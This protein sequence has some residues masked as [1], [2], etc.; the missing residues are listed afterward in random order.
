MSSSCPSAEALGARLDE[1]AALKGLRPEGAAR[2][3][4]AEA[5]EDPHEVDGE[6]ERLFAARRILV[7]RAHPV[8]DAA[9]K[10]RDEELRIVLEPGC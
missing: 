5:Q 10:H 3:E 4:D 1:R 2:R 8:G 9:G 7:R 6:V